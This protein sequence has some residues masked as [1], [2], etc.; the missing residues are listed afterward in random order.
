MD[1]SPQLSSAGLAIAV[2]LCF[3]SLLPA[4]ETLTYREVEGKDRATHV[5]SITSDLEKLGLG[6]RVE[7]TTT[8]SGAV[9]RQTFLADADLSTLSWTFSDPARSMEWTA[10]RQ[11]GKIVLTGNAKGKKV[12]REFAGEGSSWNQLFQMGLGTFVESGGA[13]FQFRSIG[14][15]GPGELKIA[16]FT[17]TRKGDETIDLAGKKVA[18]VHLR[19]S[20]SG[21]LSVFWHGDYWFRRG[22]GRFLRYRGKNRP[23]G[24]VAV[25]ELVGEEKVE[26]P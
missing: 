19:I 2:V 23:G 16:K 21:L 13:S 25:S 14:T 9:V 5:I 15:Q 3:F 6:F 10:S 26:T 4:S 8:R 12:A 7:L 17:V 24:A 18:A 22:D 20:L 1:K 11:G